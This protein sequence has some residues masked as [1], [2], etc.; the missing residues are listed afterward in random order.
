MKSCWLLIFIVFAVGCQTVK[1]KKEDKNKSI[2]ARDH[3]NNQPALPPGMN[4]TNTEDSFAK[5]AEEVKE[6]FSAY[7]EERK[8][9]NPA[10]GNANIDKAAENIKNTPKAEITQN[11]SKDEWPEFIEDIDKQTEEGLKKV[12]YGF[13]GGG[14][15]LILFGLGGQ[16]YS[17]SK[18]EKFKKTD[19]AY[20]KAK[21]LFDERKVQLEKLKT[22]LA[23]VR[24]T[25][26]VDNNYFVKTGDDYRLKT[27]DEFKNTFPRKQDIEYRNYE[28]GKYHGTLL[29]LGLNPHETDPAKY[30]LNSVQKNL[31]QAEINLKGSTDSIK[32]FERGAKA[33]NFAWIAGI[34]LLSFSSKFFELAPTEQDNATTRLLHK[35]S[36]LN[37]R[38]LIL[39]KKERI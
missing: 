18:I 36:E 5:V 13:L 12:G 23:T 19:D 30:T 37:K 1:S 26:S 7:Q 9:E 4:P 24:T 11:I 39:H 15:G 35:M 8:K 6:G 10:Q 17:S 34:V 33:G 3:N 31:D 21:G 2:I 38:I 22:A 14:I 29:S 16:Y 32:G 28:V 27:M 25:Q 20:L